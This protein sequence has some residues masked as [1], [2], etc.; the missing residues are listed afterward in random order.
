MAGTDPQSYS[1]L[2]IELDFGRIRVE[3]NELSSEESEYADVSGRHRVN[4]VQA[5]T[6][7]VVELSED[8]L[9]ISGRLVGRTAAILLAE[10]I[11]ELD[12]ESGRMQASDLSVG[13]LQ[14]S[15]GVKMTSGAGK[16]IEA[17]ISASGEASFQVTATL[18]KV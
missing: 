2:G 11:A 1:V 10:A 13:A 5:A 12:K 16:V 14:L 6:A 3:E 9:K 18:N 15:Y 4:V 17:I 7:K 8:A